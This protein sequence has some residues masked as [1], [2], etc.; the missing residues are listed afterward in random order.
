M[1]LDRVPN[2]VCARNDGD[3]VKKVPRGIKGPR[4][5]WDGDSHV[6]DRA[7]AEVLSKEKES[8]ICVPLVG[9]NDVRPML[10][11]QKSDHSIEV[12]VCVQELRKDV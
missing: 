2:L 8:K 5:N 4:M 3:W 11:I 10:T 1:G 9:G 7:R 12:A 6:G